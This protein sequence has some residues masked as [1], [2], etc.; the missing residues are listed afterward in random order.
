MI[1]MAVSACK[2]AGKYVVICGQAP[3]DFPEITKFLV[4]QGVSTVSVNPDSV[5]EMA[6]VVSEMESKLS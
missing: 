2:K 5:V 4:D 3:S 6:H 1:E